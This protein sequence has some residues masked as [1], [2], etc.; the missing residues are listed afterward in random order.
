M[1]FV[2]SFLKQHGIIMRHY[3]FR[4]ARF[5]FCFLFRNCD[6]MNLCEVL[7]VNVI[8]AEWWECYWTL[9]P[10]RSQKSNAAFHLA[11]IAP[12]LCENGYTLCPF[13]SGIGYGFRGN[14]ASVWT[15]L[16]FQFQ[17]GEKERE[18]CEFEMDFKN[19]WCCSNLSVNDDR[20]FLGA[21][22]ENWCRKIMTF[23]GLK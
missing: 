15:Y 17:M 19:F 20:N 14:Y 5:S 2:F 22:S 23:F 21:W 13:W 9:C 12:F 3:K 11:F 16:S 18:I 4:L 8:R 1:P 6:W 10:V 7:L